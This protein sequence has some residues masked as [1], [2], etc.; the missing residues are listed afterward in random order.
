MIIGVGNDQFTWMY[1]MGIGVPRAFGGIHVCIPIVIT[2]IRHVGMN[3]K[4]DFLL[5]QVL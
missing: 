3:L 5:S 1:G 2:L 4:V